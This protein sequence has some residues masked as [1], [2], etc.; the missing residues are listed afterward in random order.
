MNHWHNLRAIAG[1][2]WPYAFMCIGVGVVGMGQRA[3]GLVL[4]TGAM[5]RILFRELDHM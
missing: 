1:F 5:L 2:F 4:F 3:I